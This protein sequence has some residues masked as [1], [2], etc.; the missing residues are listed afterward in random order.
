MITKAQESEKATQISKQ[1]VC[2][3][4]RGMLATLLS[5]QTF[6]QLHTKKHFRFLNRSKHRET[7]ICTQAHASTHTPNLM[8]MCYCKVSVELGPSLSRLNSI[9]LA[10]TKTAQPQ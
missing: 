2:Y 5:I 6:V 9:K 4:V 3:P 10:L 1:A 7:H 8:Q